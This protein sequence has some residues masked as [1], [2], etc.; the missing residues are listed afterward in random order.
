MQKVNVQKMDGLLLA[1]LTVEGAAFTW[2]TAGISWVA[3]MYRAVHAG[4]L[5][6][7]PAMVVACIALSFVLGYLGVLLRNGKNS[8]RVMME[9]VD[10]RRT[11]VLAV[12]MAGY[13]LLFHIFF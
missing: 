6:M 1:L 11:I 12:L 9:F 8:I 10:R 7:A 3:Q 4:F 2:L 5:Y 13:G